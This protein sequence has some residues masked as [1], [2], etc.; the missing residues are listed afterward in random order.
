MCWAW[1]LTSLVSALIEKDDINIQRAI[2]S[3]NQRKSMF[4]IF[5]RLT[6]WL[7][8]DPSNC[9][10]RTQMQKRIFRIAIVHFLN[11]QRLQSRS[12]SIISNKQRTHSGLIKLCLCKCQILYISSNIPTHRG[13]IVVY[14]C[15]K[16]CSQH[17]YHIWGLACQKLI[18]RAG[19]SNYIP[20]IL[21]DVLTCPWPRPTSDSNNSSDTLKGSIPWLC[22]ILICAYMKYRCHDYTA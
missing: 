17:F 22:K 14:K 19:T 2:K 8:I 1:I 20:Q 9:V 21:W 13:L 3:K 18:S 4:K 10:G 5:P 6:L 7:F 16:R 15:E 11:K 12:V